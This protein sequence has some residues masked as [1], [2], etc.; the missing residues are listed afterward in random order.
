MCST[1]REVAKFLSGIAFS[2]TVGHWWLGIWG[3]HML[4]WEFG[5]F[6]FTRT[7]NTFA[8]IVWPIVLISLVWFAW[9]RT[10]SSR[11]A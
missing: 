4:P 10:P 6:T 7:F 2:E 9:L 1:A 3:G 5:W 11:S 8:M